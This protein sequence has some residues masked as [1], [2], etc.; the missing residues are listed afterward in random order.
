MA[1]VGDCN[2]DGVVT[3]NELIIGVLID[4]GTIPF[5]SC[6]AFNCNAGV[7]TMIECLVSAVS[8]ALMGC[9]V[10][11]P[12]PTPTPPTPAMP[13]TPTVTLTPATTGFSINGCVDE[14]PGSGRCG[15]VDALVQLNPLG[16]IS[17][18][19][20][21]SG[22]RFANIPPG[23]YSLSVLDRCN[24]SGCWNDVPVAIIDHDVFIDIPLIPYPPSTP[25]TQMPTPTPTRPAE[26]VVTAQQ[27][28]EEILPHVCEGLRVEPPILIETVSPA[29]DGA[30]LECCNSF[31]CPNDQEGHYGS[32][33]IRGYQ[34]GDQASAAFGSDWP[35]ATIIDVEGTSIQDRTSIPPNFSSDGGLS[36]QWKWR[37]GCWVVTGN[38]FDD[39]HF[40][41]SPQPADV[42][43]A[44]LHSSRASAVF[45]SCLP[46]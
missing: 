4:L 9:V 6:P 10:A 24:P 3:I 34:T 11:P 43:A 35:D 45:S 31:G 2:G 22:F 40:L 29:P 38:A 33:R 8:H 28:L 19:F 12:Q 25:L 36:Q 18:T 5:G 46:P 26:L 21:N 32:V 42:V 15:Q 30:V 1:C 17:Y 13:T 37:T 16:L 14:F 39:T 44:L 27:M 20:L 7:S 23:D 41:L